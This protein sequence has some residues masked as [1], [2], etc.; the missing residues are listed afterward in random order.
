VDIVDAEGRLVDTLANCGRQ[1][2]REAPRPLG[3]RV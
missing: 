3:G 2:S 1:P